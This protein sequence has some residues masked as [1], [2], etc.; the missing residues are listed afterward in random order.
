MELDK[1]T[2]VK[3]AEVDTLQKEGKVAFTNEEIYQYTR[4]DSVTL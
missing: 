3:N 1:K 2:I 4:P